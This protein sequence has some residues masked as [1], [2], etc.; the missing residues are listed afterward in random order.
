MKSVCVFC[1]SSVGREEKY[2]ESARQ[3]G[4]LLAEKNI[5]MVYGGANVGLMGM[6]ARSC[7]ENGGEVTGVITQDLVTMGVA[8]D[9]LAELRVVKTMHERKSLMSELADGYLVLPGGIGTI[10]E[11]LEVFTWMQLGLHVKPVGLLNISSF[12]DYLMKFLLHMVQEGFL[13][14]EHYDMLL[15]NENINSL[16]NSL[17]TIKPKKLE[18]WFDI[19]ENRTV[20]NRSKVKGKR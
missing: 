2:L 14:Q 6:A 1:G 13:R 4:A 12:F 16:L 11:A 3:T 5:R 10:E 19:E 20:Q 8:H 9:S 18:K 7:T 17:M 15:I